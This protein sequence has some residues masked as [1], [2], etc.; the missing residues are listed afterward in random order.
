M[1]EVSEKEMKR[2]REAQRQGR[3]SNDAMS[4]R[5]GPVHVD[6]LKQLAAWK[7]VSQSDLVRQL[8]DAEHKRIREKREALRA[9]SLGAS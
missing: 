2:R 3:M 4:F 9:K 1:A 5:L 7:D 6:R 8:V